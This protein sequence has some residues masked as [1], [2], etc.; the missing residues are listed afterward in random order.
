MFGFIAVL[1][2]FVLLLLIVITGFRASERAVN[3][4]GRARLEREGLRVEA[5]EAGP[6]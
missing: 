5:T 3:F 4:S 6:R 1:G 2:L